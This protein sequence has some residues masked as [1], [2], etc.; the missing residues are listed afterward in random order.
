MNKDQIQNLYAFLDENIRFDGRTK[1]DYRKV[2]VKTG[3]SVT[4][5]GSAQ[6]DIGNTSVMAGV[7]IEVGTPFSD[8]PDEGVLMVGVELSQ[9]ANENFESGPPNFDAIELARVTDRGIRES[10]AI[11]VK[12]LCIVPG[13]KVLIVNV[14]I[15]I[16]ND[17]GNLLDACSLAAM[18]AIKDT[19]I[20]K[21]NKDNSLDYDNKTKDGL[22][23]NKIPL[24]VTVYKIGSHLIVDPSLKEMAAIDTRLTVTSIEDGTLCAL[25]KGKD[26]VLSKDDILEI[27]N[28]SVEKSKE[29][30]KFI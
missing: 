29:L 16:L 28:L 14:D 3:V 23:I 5:E 2:S 11:D 9:I 15:G 12:K 24:G 1:T 10:K 25:Q 30:R 21:L 18:A 8:K 17:D 13:E 20:P 4:A 19:R 22:P 27:I 26:G 7:K 6:V